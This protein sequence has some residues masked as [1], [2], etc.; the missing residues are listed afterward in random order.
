MLA[1]LGGCARKRPALPIPAESISF[2]DSVVYFDVDGMNWA[3][4]MRSIVSLGPHTNDGL[5]AGRNQLSLSINDKYV[6]VGPVC[7]VDLKFIAAGEILLPRWKFA[8]QADAAS[9]QRWNSYVLGVRTHEYFHRSI[10]QAGLDSAYRAAIVQA[11]PTCAELRPKVRAAISAAMA[12][13]WEQQR[14]FDNEEKD[15][16]ANR[17]PP[18]EK[19]AASTNATVQQQSREYRISGT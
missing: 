11:A 9:Q 6:A 4:V 3:E 18:R 19:L 1:T 17:R 2:R 5:K 7:V 13:S 14:R 15:A 8:S 12:H 10:F 16:Q